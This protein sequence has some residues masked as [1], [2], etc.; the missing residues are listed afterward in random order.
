MDELDERGRNWL[1]IEGSKRRDNRSFLA[2]Q[3]TS[4]YNASWE[5]TR[6]GDGSDAADKTG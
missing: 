5:K 4:T 6:N 1:V 3:S 2:Q